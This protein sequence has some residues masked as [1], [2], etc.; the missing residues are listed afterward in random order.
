[1]GNV[2]MYKLACPFYRR[3]RDFTV[4]FCD[5]LVSGIPTC[6]L[7]DF[8]PDLDPSSFKSFDEYNEFEDR[9]EVC[10]HF[11]R[12]DLWCVPFPFAKSE[13]LFFD[14]LCL[15]PTIDGFGKCS[16]DCSRFKLLIVCEASEAT[17]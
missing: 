12:S 11:V 14:E 13:C 15:H 8:Y 4:P 7:A 10:S 1:M 17:V 9:W 16:F 2:N 6:V 3:F 5:N